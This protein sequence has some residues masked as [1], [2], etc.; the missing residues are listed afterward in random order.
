VTFQKS[1]GFKPSVGRLHCQCRID[2][3]VDFSHS[4]VLYDND[5]GSTKVREQPMLIR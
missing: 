5:K 3:K 2:A 4:L 1:T